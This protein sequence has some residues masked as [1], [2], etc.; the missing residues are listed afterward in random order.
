M[1][2]KNTVFSL[3]KVL[4]VKH[5]ND[6]KY[7][8]FNRKCDLLLTLNVILI[9]FG[10]DSTK[11]WH[12]MARSSSWYQSLFSALTS[13]VLIDRS[14][15]QCLC[16]FIAL[17]FSIWVTLGKVPGCSKTSSSNCLENLYILSEVWYA[18]R[19][20]WKLKFSSEKSF[21]EQT[22]SLLLFIV[23]SMSISCHAP[24]ALSLP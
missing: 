1:L 10:M 8:D 6:K 24:S 2:W 22:L 4:I 21:L 9:Q 17:R 12:L 15:L 11:N 13:L 18:A 20:C 23:L 7:Y 5:V 14:S 3:I 16:L 19:S